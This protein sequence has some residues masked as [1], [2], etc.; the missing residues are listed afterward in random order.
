MS[1][2][3]NNNKDSINL[4]Q[5]KL[6]LQEY[7]K[8]LLNLVRISADVSGDFSE[9]KF[10]DDMSELLCEAGVYD[11]IQKDT[12]IN[13]RKGIR[14]DGWNWNKTERMLSAVITKFSNDED[15]VTISKSDIDKLG[16][17][18]SK[19]I[20]SINDPKFKNS[21]DPSDSALELAE[22]MSSY[23]ND[24]GVDG[25]QGFRPAA[26]KF[27][28]I[29][30]TDYLLSE[31]VDEKKIK[32]ENIHNKKARIEIWDL[33]R[34]R[35]LTLS[36]TESEP[37]DVDFSMY[38]DGDGLP[39]LPANISESHISS[40]ICVM[41]GTVLRDL[42]E[43]F[44]Q[45]LLESNVRTFL[46]FRGKVNQGMK[47][48][49]LQ[50]PE[51]FFA[52]NNGL[53]VTASNIELDDSS[54]QLMIKKLDNMQ[55]VNGGQTTSAIYF[56]PLSKGKQQG[57]DFR[58]IDLTKVFV[59]MKLT[60]IENDEDSEII[61][62][63]VARYANSQN[64]IQAADLISNHP[65]HRAIEKQSRSVWAPPSENSA[66]QTRW[67]YERARG[68]YQT[69]I[70]AFRTPAK[71]RS[72][73][74]ENPRNQMFTKT[75]MAKYEN[76]WRMRPWEVKLGAQGN[77][78]KIGSVLIKEWDEN[79]DNFGIMFFKDLVAKAILFKTTDSAILK[80]DWYKANA[81]LKA[82]TSTYALALLLFKLEKL[83]WRLNLKRIWETQKLSDSLIN[84][85]LDLAEA[86]REN[87]LD[88]DF[89]DGNANPSMF[90][91]KII[92]WEK[93][94]EMDYELTLISKDDLLTKT[95]EN[96]R[97][98]INDQLNEENAEI[99]IMKFCTDISDEEWSNIYEFLKQFVPKE[100]KDMK[101][102]NKFTLLS[103]PT[104]ARKISYPFDY[105]TAKKLR[106]MAIDNGF[107]IT[108]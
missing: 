58:N 26:N 98:N 10:F 90:A 44:G 93:F 102:L 73:Q 101:T 5:D 22:E 82:E 70:L 42:F 48:T 104:M 103:N 53:T 94:K 54:G 13:S 33:K 39:T 107:I 96:E 2:D 99:D 23:L 71:V 108:N 69:K 89:R 62:S 35:D 61:K 12:Y 40:Y 72:F 88:I 29:V 4:E 19:F 81:G 78:E 7:K 92:A 97:K 20:S 36:G 77:L 37:C 9:S 75:D 15:L 68:Q 21:L 16:K 60:V 105:E 31:R 47:S 50:N 95:Q 79:P 6:E 27:R 57:I 85:I 67:F 76:T 24:L 17:Q 8:D 52:Y 14:I 49:L 51:N 28:V 55:I 59:Q 84:Q 34:I 18:A 56:S 38:C 66:V 43:N 83:G 41:P 87:L 3:K 64:A 65:I 86:V 74:G 106:N 91:R 100:S 25:D 80:S 1:E 45:R 11:D 63:N 32:I 30:L 46:Q